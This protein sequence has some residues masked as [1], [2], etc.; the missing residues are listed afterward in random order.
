MT[1]TLPGVFYSEAHEMEAMVMPNAFDGGENALELIRQDH[2]AFAPDQMSLGGL[3]KA[4]K[5]NLVNR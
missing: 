2:D 5:D 4:A 3:A 1:V